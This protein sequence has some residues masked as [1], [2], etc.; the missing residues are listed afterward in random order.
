MIR[1][2]VAVMGLLY[3]VGLASAQTQVDETRPIPANATIEIINP[4]GSI[5]IAGAE[6]SDLH[7]TGT[8]GRRVT[9]LDISTENEST[10]VEVVIPDN[11]RDRDAA[12]KVTVPAGASLIVRG[13]SSTI[14]VTGVTGALM[15]SDVS[16]EITA[17]IAPKKLTYD[18]VSGDVT[19]EAATTEVEG[20][21]IS[22]DTKLTGISGRLE[23]ET[24][25]G[26][27]E[28]SGGV[29]ER[30]RFKSV[31]GDMTFAGALTPSARLRGSSVSGRFDLTLNSD[32]SAEFEVE[33]LS[34][35]ITNEFGAPAEHED[36]ASPGTKLSFKLGQGEG[37]VKV[38]TVSG[39]I[40]FKKQQS[41]PLLEKN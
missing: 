28:V 15:L 22:G 2:S 19:I 30:V 5:S 1:T 8:L 24:M 12:L 40:T 7:V 23:A 18:S 6:S 3:I 27:V 33:S 21:N 17:K 10:T 14:D 35:R 41:P 36:A 13:V 25:S 4:I 26:A 31:S 9:M 38:E 34:G 16:G 29:F 32:L 11:G 37:R 20:K 39:P